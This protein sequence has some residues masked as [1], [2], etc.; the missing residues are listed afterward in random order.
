MVRGWGAPKYDISVSQKL[1]ERPPN[2]ISTIE[3]DADLMKKDEKKIRGRSGKF[4]DFG[5]WKF[6]GGIFPHFWGPI[7]KI[8]NTSKDI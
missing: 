6:Q 8:F 1:D 3:T 4:W 2:F 5:V 7:P